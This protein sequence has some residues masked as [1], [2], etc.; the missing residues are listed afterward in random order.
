MAAPVTDNTGTNIVV[1]NCPSGLATVVWH[2]QVCALC[3]T[4][5]ACKLSSIFR[6]VYHQC[7]QSSP[8]SRSLLLCFIHIA[9]FLQV[10]Y[11]SASTWDDWHCSLNPIGII[12]CND[13]LSASLG[14]L[15]YSSAAVPAMDH[16]SVCTR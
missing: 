5:H 3:V 6:S 15:S 7:L 14:R 13:D 2:T 12:L 11:R 9:F 1:R 4:L 8:Q 16:E 10:I